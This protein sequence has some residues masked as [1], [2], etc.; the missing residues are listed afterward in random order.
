MNVFLWV[1][2]SYM[3]H[4]F[5]PK[6]SLF[7]K[8]YF[9]LCCGVWALFIDL[10]WPGL[11]RRMVMSPASEHQLGFSNIWTK[12]WWWLIIRLNSDFVSLH[13]P[14]LTFSCT[15]NF[16]LGREFILFC[17]NQSVASDVIFSLHES[18]SVFLIKIKKCWF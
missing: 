12:I 1:M 5:L 15:A 11:G 9:C 7:H 6:L 17:L 10:M 16:L 3:K 13:S 14:R 18:C 4:S 2:A 8:R